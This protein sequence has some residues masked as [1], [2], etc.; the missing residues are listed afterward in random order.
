MEVLLN[1]ASSLFR[2]WLL[3]KLLSSQ[4]TNLTG[5][6]VKKKQVY[7]IYGKHVSHQ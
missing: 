4:E 2:D 6:T 7:E 1:F 5:K 3:S